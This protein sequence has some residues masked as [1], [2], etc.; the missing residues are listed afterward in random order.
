[1]DK[2]SELLPGKISTEPEDLVCYGFDASG[3]EAAPTAV[4]WAQDVLDVVKIMNF[5]QASSIPLIPRGAG[6]GMTGGSV[7][8]PEIRRGGKGAIILSIEKMN[9]IL[10]IDT[11][12]LSVLVEPGVINGRLQRELQRYNLF[13]PP[14]PASMN[15]CTIGGNVAENA[16]GPRALKYGVTRDYVMGL[17]AVL[18]NGKI[19]NTGVRTAKG[20]VGYDLTRLLVGS[21]G[22]LAV[23]TKIRLRVLPMPEDVVALL[24]LFK[25]IGQ[26]G[27]AVKQILSKR[28]IPRTLEFMDG[29]AV[30]AVEGYKPVGLPKDAEAILLI[31]LDGHPTV[32]TKEAEKISS[33]C[34]ALDGEVIMAED[35]SAREKLWEARRAI[36]PA[37]YHLMPSKIN[38]DI[39]VPRN[40]IPDMLKILRRLSQETGIKIVNFGHAGDGNIHVNLMVD[41]NNKEEYE[42]ALKLVKEIFRMTLELGG[43]ISGEHGVGLTKAVYISMEIPAVELDLMKKIKSV[44]DPMN[45]LNPGK[46]FP[47]SDRG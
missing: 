34:A 1:V 10:D 18:P 43:T 30:R 31:E 23:I 8:S 46:I 17:E 13:Y 16:G 5:A 4:V 38:E 44:F 21:E 27:N 25:D 14:D 39:V 41:R 12:N 19:I 26:A 22:T 47:S 32:I 37:L 20:V 28:I 35:E 7:P 6:T 2:L 3:L 15:F 36:S 33:L 45:I 11:E 42:K 9:K 24:V 29:E 40:R